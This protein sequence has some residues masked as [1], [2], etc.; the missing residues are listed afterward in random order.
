MK[1]EKK[2]LAY[3]KATGI[4]TSHGKFH[5]NLG[6]E[7]I[8]KILDLLGNPHKNLKFVHI[9]GTNGK[10]ST[11]AIL[12]SILTQSGIKTGLFTSP[13]VF[14]YTER[15]KINGEEIKKDFFA[16]KIIK[17]T[18]LA[19]TKNIDLTEFEI[20][21]AVAFEYFAQNKVD[22]VVLETGLGGRLDATNIIETNLCSIIT[23]IDFDHTERLGDTIEKISFEK[24]GIIKP[25]CPVVAGIQN[26]GIEVIKKAAE[27]NF[28]PCYFVQTPEQ[29]PKCSLLGIWQKENLSLA[30]MAVEILKEK[31]FEIKEE[32]V[33]KALLNVKH[34][35]RF[36]YSKEKNI[37]I[38][39]AHNPNGAKALRK[40]LEH[41]FPNQ[42]FNFVFGCLKN[43]DY[44]QMMENLFR[45]KDNIYF[46]TFEN[47]NSSNYDELKNACKYN[48]KPFDNF[49]NPD[50]KL[51]VVCGSFY[52]IKEVL[53][54]LN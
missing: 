37:L 44:P 52:M 5:I 11:S 28:S 42:G 54:K 27:K 35:C 45:E 39:G 43:K 18:K 49:A 4:L 48:S 14:E 7:R 13:H 36:E 9:A 29:L 46:Y 1:S 24:A 3:K 23:N 25:E 12:S 30:L 26:I 8:G 31:G 2:N 21:T 33:E 6:L 16:E 10:G 20:I 47:P 34:P 51:T 50:N 15:I 38:D 17:I 40:S 53:K 41:Y 19:E 22:M 32:T